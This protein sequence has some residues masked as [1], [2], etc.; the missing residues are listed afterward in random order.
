MGCDYIDQEGLSGSSHAS[1]Y[2]SRPVL[3]LGDPFVQVSVSRR[4]PRPWAP[5]EGVAAPTQRSGN[6]ELRGR[7]NEQVIH[8]RSGRGPGPG[9]FSWVPRVT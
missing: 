8:S 3:R 9:G 2:S 6:A 5:K 7:S 1:L 4:L